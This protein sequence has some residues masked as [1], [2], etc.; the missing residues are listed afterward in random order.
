MIKHA[1]KI[2]LGGGLLAVLAFG[3]SALSQ[4]GAS[5]NHSAA[6]AK[7]VR[8]VKHK[9]HASELTTGRDGDT[10]QSGDQTT[11]DTAGSG[12]AAESTGSEAPDSSSSESSGS[13]V[14]NNDGPG[15]HADEPGN[16]N[17][18]HQFNGQ[19]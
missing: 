8:V 18:D 12:Q 16:A 9:A 7:H 14:A 1:K 11:P 3:G 19:E 5:S 6:K 15:G 4:A 2:L 17:A 13:E 10:I